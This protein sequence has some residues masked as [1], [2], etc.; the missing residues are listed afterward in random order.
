MKRKIGYKYR[1]INEISNRTLLRLTRSRERALDFARAWNE[2][3]QEKHPENSQYRPA[4]VYREWKIDGTEY[5]ES[6]N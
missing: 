2:K 1:V 5:G 3:W 4:F 6:L